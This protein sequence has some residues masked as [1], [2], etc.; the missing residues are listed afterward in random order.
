MLCTILTH[1]V[2]LFINL[3]LNLGNK[4]DSLSIPISSE[5]FKLLRLGCSK[6][7]LEKLQKVK[8]SGARVVPEAKGHVSSLLRAL[9]WLHTHPVNMPDLRWLHTHPVNMPDLR[10]L[11]THPVNMP[12]LRWLH[13]HPVNMPDLRW[14][15]THPVNMPDLRWLHTHPVNMSDP[16]RIRSGSAWQYWPEAGRMIFA[17]RICFRSGSVWPNPDS[18]PEL[19]RIRAGFDPCWF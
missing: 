10:W 12:D 19:N 9:R 6:H 1:L 5:Y 16:I 17:N 7:F 8:T 14:L 11:H 3:S 4:N 13:T 18:Q 15:H 2:L